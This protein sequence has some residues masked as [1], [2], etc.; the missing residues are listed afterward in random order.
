MPKSSTF[1]I[2]TMLVF[3]FF[4]IMAVLVF[5]GVFPIFNQGGSGVN[6]EVVVWGTMP[7][8]IMIPLFSDITGS[9]KN[10]QIVYVKKNAASFDDNFIEA[11][12]S[13]RGPDLFFLPQN[14]ILKYED[15]IMPIPYDSISER[16]FKSTYVE[17][18]ELYLSANGILGLPIIVDPMV[19]YW[20]RNMFSSGGIPE[21]PSYWDE[22]AT[23]VPKL[24]K[25]DKA[26]NILESAISFGEFKN[27]SYAKDILAMLMMQIGNTL[28]VRDR[29]K[30]PRVTLLEEQGRDIRSADTALNFFTEFS[31]PAK[32]VYSWNKSLPSSRDSFLG[33]RL[34]I[35]FG[36]ASEIGSLRNKNPHLNFDVTG[37]PKPRG[38][39]AKISLGRVEAVAIVRASKNLNSAIFVAKEMAGAPFAGA[40]AK[41]LYLP[42][43]R[44]DLLSLRPKD[45]YLQFFYDSA[46]VSRGWLDPDP[47]GTDQIFGEMV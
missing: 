22:I 19:M 44:R 25:K 8:E 33:G 17:E 15:K 42:P 35:Y 12:A 4:A 46:L 37:V 43:A 11:L 21:P 2:I 31:D 39:K 13:G 38:N 27:V 34:A 28:V 6:G 45:S 20:N 23:V 40:L 16:D 29:Q 9:N 5:S 26:G 3:G 7:E 10:L 32:T 14:F 24:G 36:Y 30:I 47:A 1:Q 41:N 18:G